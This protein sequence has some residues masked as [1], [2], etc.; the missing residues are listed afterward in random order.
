MYKTSQGYS[1]FPEADQVGQAGQRR[2]DGE[3]LPQRRLRTGPTS[4]CRL[5]ECWKDTSSWT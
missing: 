2:R 5:R 3:V 4:F 1:N